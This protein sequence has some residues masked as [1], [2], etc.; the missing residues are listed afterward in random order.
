MDDS[1]VAAFLAAGFGLVPI[2]RGEK[3]P[4]T[5]AWQKRENV[6]FG[7]EHVTAFGEMNAGLVHEHS[8]TCA[9]DIDDFD[10]ADAWLLARGLNLEALFMGE[11]TVTVSS[12]IPNRG[13]LIYRLPEGA[14]PLPTVKIKDDAGRIL[15]ELRCAGA[16]DVIGGRHPSGTNYTVTGDPATMPVLPRILLALW[17]SPINLPK[18]QAPADAEAIPEGARNATL[19]SLAGT[20]RRRTFSAEAIRAALQQTNLERC[21]PPLPD[22]EIAAI[23][24]SVGRYKLEHDEPRKTKP[25]HIWAK[26]AAPMLGCDYVIKGVLDR[27]SLGLIYGAWS[28]GKSFFALDV[29]L[30]VAT[31]L[32]WRGRRVKHC[33]VMYVAAEAGEGVQKRVYAWKAEHGLLDLKHIPFVIRTRAVALLDDLAVGRFLDELATTIA[34]FPES[35]LLVI[36]DTVS[37]SLSGGDENRDLPKLIAA[38]DRIR[39]ELSATV[40]LVHHAGKDKHK[41]PRG[42]SSLIAAVDL[43]L[44]VHAEPV[45]SAVIEKA[46]DAPKGTLFAFE[47]KTFCLGTDEEGDKLTTCVVEH[48]A[49]GVIHGERTKGRSL[50]NGTRLVL[51]AI[52]KATG[53]HGVFGGGLPPNLGIPVDVRAVSIGHAR[54]EHR[55]VYGE[56]DADRKRGARALQQAFSR[57][58]DELVGRGIVAMSG[59]FVWQTPAR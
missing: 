49:D 23:A 3:G 56:R 57:G 27:L 19:T 35:P 20:M 22:D 47:L 55:R 21:H 54:D 15:L 30:H 41:G 26:D 44:E 28:V 52:Q 7:V 40:L 58:L 17:Q 36:V 12:G 37:R 31:G 25:P 6:I 9:I 2:P 38:C 50:P 29:G 13:K 32:P 14:A 33:L 42:H 46:R 59:P 11:G 53:E 5:R 4:R 45:R 24:A 34:Y 18:A 48:A 51:D 39:D 43:A 8:G 16:Q 1:T 10:A